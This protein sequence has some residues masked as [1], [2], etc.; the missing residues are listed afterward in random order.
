M[1]SNLQTMVQ[2]LLFD[3]LICEFGERLS[4][5]YEMFHKKLHE[6]NWY[7]LPIEIQRMYLIFMAHTQQTPNISC[8]GNFTCT[9]N[10]FK[11]VIFKKNDVCCFNNVL[12]NVFFSSMADLTQRVFIF[13]GS[14]SNLSIACFFIQ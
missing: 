1:A 12:M 14:S 10:T 13:Y 7:S 2:L 3:F 5:K 9:P 4:S 8:Y 6:C 11:K